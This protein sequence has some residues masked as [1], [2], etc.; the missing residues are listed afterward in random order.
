MI[1][2]VLFSVGEYDYEGDVTDRGVFLHFGNT[3]IK[4]CDTVNDFANFVKQIK[5]IQDELENYS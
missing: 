2:K 3:K 4:A 5:N 1:Q